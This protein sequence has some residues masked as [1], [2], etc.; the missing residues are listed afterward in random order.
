MGGGALQ[1]GCGLNMD[2]NRYTDYRPGGYVSVTSFTI[3]SIPTGTKG[4][5]LEPLRI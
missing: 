4:W 3:A 1:G 5:I 2:S